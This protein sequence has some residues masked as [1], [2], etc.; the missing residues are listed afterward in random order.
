M[1]YEKHYTGLESAQANW[2]KFNFY[3]SKNYRQRYWRLSLH[4]VGGW[5]KGSMVGL[6][7]GRCNYLGGTGWEVTS[8]TVHFGWSKVGTTKW[9]RVTW[10]GSQVDPWH[11]FIWRVGRAGFGMQSPAWVKRAKWRKVDKEMQKAAEGYSEYCR[12]NG[13]AEEDMY[14]EQDGGDLAATVNKEYK[15]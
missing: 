5:L 6:W 1:K 9:C 4:G 14:G 15:L 2:W 7:V 11:T 8:S 10:H 13:I 12:V 3:S